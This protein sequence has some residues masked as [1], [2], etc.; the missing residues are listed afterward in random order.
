M[1]GLFFAAADCLKSLSFMY[2]LETF[3][4]CDLLIIPRYTGEGETW[5]GGHKWGAC[6][7][8]AARLLYSFLLLFLMGHFYVCTN[9]SL[10]CFTVGHV[11]GRPRNVH[12]QNPCYAFPSLM[13]HLL[14]DPR[15]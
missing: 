1:Y 9:T 10:C 8:A 15:V 3:Y 12:Y 14:Y 4:S 6:R 5:R 11:G 13:I 7:L 2:K